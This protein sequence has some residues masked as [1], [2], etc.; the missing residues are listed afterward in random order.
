MA[1]ILITGGKGILGRAVVPKLLT[2]G[3]DVAVATRH[4]GQRTDGVVELYL[5]LASGDGLDEALES[6]DVVIHAATDA[7]HAN[8]VDV[9][10]TVALVTVAGKAGVGHFVYPSIVGID[11]HAFAY[12]RVKKAV[13]DIIERSGIP[14]T[15]QRITQFHQFPVRLADAQR[16][17]PVVLAPSNV[18][19]QVLDVTVAA[20]RLADLVDAGPSRRA[21]DLGGARPIPVEHLIRSYLRARGSHRPV[22]AVR[23]PG[24]TGRDFRAGLQLSNDHSGASPTWEEFL[25]AI[26]DR[27]AVV[28]T[29]GTVE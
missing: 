17:L 26:S 21:P 20:E 12:Y 6:I 15:I 22:L 10:G 18:E 24:A 19:F 4:P 7:V 1:K 13:E 9:A 16:W 8:Q 11:D 5:N 28:G 3:H 29:C 14:H 27:R 23:V 2:R 25:G